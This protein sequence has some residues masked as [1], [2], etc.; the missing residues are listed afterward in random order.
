MEKWNI[1]KKIGVLAIA[2]LPISAM[3]VC[4]NSAEA[5][6]IEIY[7]ANFDFTSVIKAS[8]DGGDFFILKSSS[9]YLPSFWIDT[10]ASNRLYV[11]VNLRESSLPDTD[12]SKYNLYFTDTYGLSGVLVRDRDGARFGFS[13][14]GGAG[15]GLLD[16]TEPFDRVENFRYWSDVFV[17]DLNAPFHGGEYHI[18][19]EF[20]TLSA[21][22]TRSHDASVAINTSIQSATGSYT[23]MGWARNSVPEPAGWAMIISGFALTGGALRR[24]R[25]NLKNSMT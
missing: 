3:L 21:L 1:R 12:F 13:G 23:Y 18:E 4:V 20:I 8:K 24:Q 15:G 11:S 22:M 16:Q 2:L 19:F 25:F 14:Q 9:F 5:R 7:T 6:D 17:Y 10:L